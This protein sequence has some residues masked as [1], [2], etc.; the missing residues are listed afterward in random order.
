MKY[1]LMTLMLLSIILSAHAELNQDDLNKIRLIVK[2]EVD[3][4]IKNSETRMKEYVDTKI[5][6]LEKNMNVQFQH[7]GGKINILTAIVCALIGL[8]GVIIAL[9][10]WRTRKDNQTLEKQIETLTQDIETLKQQR[11]QM[12]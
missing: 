5:D 3:T 7:I 2:D 8:I 4:A 6:P 1:F 11:I 10:A 9:P 12:P